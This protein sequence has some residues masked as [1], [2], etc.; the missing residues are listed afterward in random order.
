[1]G[2]QEDPKPFDRGT[3]NRQ[4]LAA[5]LESVP[6]TIWTTD[7]QL[8]L[9]F[10]QGAYLRRVDIDPGKLIGRTIQS[11]LLDG[12]DDHP[13]IEAHVTALAGYETTVRIEWGGRLYTARLAPLR[14]HDDQITG[15]AGILVEIG[16]MADEESTLRESEVRLQRAVDSNL[17]GIVFGNDQGHVTDANDAFLELAGYRREDL[18]EDQ[19]SWPALTP[20]ERHQRQI[21]ALDEII[22]TGRC[23][24]FESELIRKDGSR[25][26][27]L[28]GAVRLS[29]RRRE[30]VAFVM[31]LTDRERRVGRV[32]LEL[33]CADVLLNARDVAAATHATAE[34][35]VA[36]LPVSS[37]AIWSATPDG[38][39]LVARLGDLDEN[40]PGFESLT[41]RV[42][43][44]GETSWSADGAVL[45]LPFDAAVGGRGAIVLAGWRGGAPDDDLTSLCARIGRRLG[46]F[47]RQGSTEG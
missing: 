14:A 44:T 43:A 10:I 33:A 13:L 34:L 46:A 6:A 40:G 19:L 31:D 41:E 36:H 4:R 8:V 39:R 47:V 26:P 32:K 17:I 20:V 3:T 35:L 16:W 42:I 21:Q 30:G 22:A 7:A 37:A 38:C 9:T 24:P 23:T 29:A 5:F 18:V 11:L 25:V 45:A 1:M 15:C 28:I 12:R 27:V 2:M